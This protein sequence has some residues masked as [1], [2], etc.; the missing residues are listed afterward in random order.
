M[1]YFS[2]DSNAR[3]D[4]RII[5]LRMKYGAAGYGVFFMV[6]ER[7]RDATGYMCATDYNAISYDL[8]V[9]AE[10]IRAV[11]EDFELFKFTDDHAFF[12]SSSMLRR[13]KQKDEVSRKRSEA[14]KRGGRPR[15]P[16]VIPSA[17]E[18]DK[19]AKN[20]SP[21]ADTQADIKAL[22]GEHEQE[23]MCMKFHINQAELSKRYAQFILDCQCRQT[24][25]NDRR[26]AI[27][28]FNDWLRIVLEAETR[29]ANEQSERTSQANKR[30]GVQATTSQPQ[31]YSGAF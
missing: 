27:N 3:N 19:P 17:P 26:D 24:D 11:V 13:M 4:E 25:H 9:D 22:I 15:K 31:D 18:S 12:Y 28:H 16:K 21:P 6:L 14:G 20:S 7:M 2:H 29:K 30:R 23:C 8:R 10:L 1:N 5:R